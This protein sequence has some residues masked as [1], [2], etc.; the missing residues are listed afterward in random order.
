MNRH[1]VFLGNYFWI[2][3]DGHTLGTTR[4]CGSKL[5]FVPAWR[6]TLP[7]IVVP[8]PQPATRDDGWEIWEVVFQLTV[9]TWW[10]N[11]DLLLV[12]FPYPVYLPVLTTVHAQYFEGIST[13][14][15]MYLRRHENTHREIWY[16]RAR[17]H[18][19]YSTCER[20]HALLALLYALYWL[21]LHT[22]FV[23]WSVS[24][25]LSCLLAHDR[26]VDR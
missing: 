22:S 2:V 24:D 11:R 14:G 16:E 1:N 5:L 15:N 6:S 3:W 25:L 20:L 10:V 9:M 26:Y 18:N 4:C 23:T 13:M 8:S 17:A 21:Y 12:V 19:I 7:W